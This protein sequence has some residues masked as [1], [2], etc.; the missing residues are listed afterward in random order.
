MLSLVQGFF[1]A[2]RAEPDAEVVSYVAELLADGEVDVDDLSDLLAGH[3][4]E[5][6]EL[7]LVEREARVTELLSGAFQCKAAAEAAGP[8]KLVPVVLPLLIAAS[9]VGPAKGQSGLELLLELTQAALT[10]AALPRDFVAHVLARFPDVASAADHLLETP[11]TALAA[12]AARFAAESGALKEKI[13]QRYDLVETKAPGSSSQGV[14]APRGPELGQ[15]GAAFSVKPAKTRYHGSEVV[16]QTG[17]K[18]VVE[19]LSP[20]W[21]GGSRG[22]V[23]PKGK[24]GKAV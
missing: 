11:A 6:G 16:T 2:N 5:F 9:S 24:R 18:Y 12:E 3:A 14:I 22:K 21:D 1:A 20:D 17:A 8:T 23:K 15:R 7:S 19:K 10:Q 4:P 13:L